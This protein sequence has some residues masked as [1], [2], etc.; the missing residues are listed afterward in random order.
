M[1]SYKVTKN[2]T[3][4]LNIYNLTDAKYFAQYYQGHA[5]P[6]SGRWAMLSWRVR[7]EPPT[8]LP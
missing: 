8:L 6:A 3:L 4:Q 1:T 2:S 7:L 5:V